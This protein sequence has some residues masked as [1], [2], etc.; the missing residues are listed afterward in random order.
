[1]ERSTLPRALLACAASV[2]TSH[3]HAQTP[4]GAPPAQGAAPGA[5][6]APVPGT[7]LIREPPPPP[8]VVA[9]YRPEIDTEDGGGLEVAFARAFTSGVSDGWMLRV[10]SA[11][12][13]QAAERDRRRTGPL[14]GVTQGLEGWTANGGHGF[15]FRGLAYAGWREPLSVSRRAAGVVSL[16]GLG[17]HWFLIDSVRGEGGV[18]IFAPTASVDLGLDLGGLRLTG[19]GS[20]TYRWQ[21]SADDRAQYSVGLVLLAHSELWDG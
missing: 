21:W 11:Y 10:S 4:Q 8:I 5:R 6:A 16:F 19:Q 20:A 1:M 12:F 13:E 15:S 17:W 14:A 9:P 7:T 18:G 2:L 3:A